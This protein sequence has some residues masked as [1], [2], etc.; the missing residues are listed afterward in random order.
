MKSTIS[1]AR[2]SG[3]RSFLER[4][5][6]SRKPTCSVISVPRVGHMWGCLQPSKKKKKK[7]SVSKFGER[8]RCVLYAYN[9]IAWSH[10]RFFLSSRNPD[11]DFAVDTFLFW[12]SYYYS[13]VLCTLRSRRFA[14]FLRLF[15][16][17]AFFQSVIVRHLLIYV[18]IFDTSRQ[19]Y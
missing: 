18:F 16:Q 10:N 7:W 3:A 15:L 9:Y 12:P 6:N 8:Y 13:P 2:S 4:I 5:S 1:A 19:F 11:L 14:V 17:R